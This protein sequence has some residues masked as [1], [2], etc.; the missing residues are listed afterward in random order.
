VTALPLGIVC[1]HPATDVLNLGVSGSEKFGF[2][3]GITLDANAR[4]DWAGLAWLK[5]SKDARKYPRPPTT[6]SGIVAS[7][8]APIIANVIN[9]LMFFIPIS[10]SRIPQFTQGVF[11][12]AVGGSTEICVMLAHACRGVSWY[13]K[14]CLTY[15]NYKDY[16]WDMRKFL[17]V[18]CLTVVGLIVP[19]VLVG[20]GGAVPTYAQTF[21]GDFS[22]NISASEVTFS[23]GQNIEIE[24]VFTN[25][26]GKRHEIVHGDPLILLFIPRDGEMRILTRNYDVIEIDEVRNKT[27]LTGDDLVRGRHELVATAVFS[28]EGSSPFQSIRIVSNTIFI[29]V[30]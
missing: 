11:P 25:L 27:I 26:S 9:F 18:M 1:S 29:N 17:G 10:L 30:I 19:M 8:T 12:L 21:C 7:T 13:L 28:R 6:A 20:C 3:N 5:S 16:I 2:V 14:R 24:V 23:S 4:C 15:I 22:L